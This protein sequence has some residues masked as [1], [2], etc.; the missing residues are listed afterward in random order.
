MTVIFITVKPQCL[1][2]VGAQYIFISGKEKDDIVPAFKLKT[3]HSE[4]VGEKEPTMRAENSVIGV[5]QFGGSWRVSK[6]LTWGTW[7]ELSLK[8]QM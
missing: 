2:T 1:D 8:K 4:A 5:Q 3:Q 6:G 7:S